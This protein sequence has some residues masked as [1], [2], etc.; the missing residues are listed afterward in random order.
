MLQKKKVLGIYYLTTHKGDCALTI[1][2]ICQMIQE[3]NTHALA[4]CISQASR[5]LPG[6]KPFWQKAQRYLIAQ[7]RSP[8]CSVPFP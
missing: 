8:E 2:D 4:Q 1:E 7:I 5:N 6:S 3:G